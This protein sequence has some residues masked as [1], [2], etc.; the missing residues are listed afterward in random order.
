MKKIVIKKGSVMETL[1]IP[2]YGKKKANELYPDLFVDESCKDIFDK[3]VIHM[4]EPKK[5]KMKIG[6]IMAGT[7]QFDLAEVCRNYLQTHPEASVV[8]LGCGLD[9]TFNLLSAIDAQGYNIDFPDVI[10]ARNQLLKKS[11]NETNI[12]CDLMDFTWMDKIDFEQDKGAVFFASGL[13]YYFKKED[14]KKLFAEMAERFPGGKIAFDATN[15]KGLKK[16]LKTWLKPS[17]MGDVGI[18]FSL[19]DEQEILAWSDKIKSVVKKGY[20]SGYRPID[21]RFG[22]A[23]NTLFRYAEKTNMSQIIEIEFKK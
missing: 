12:A 23:V 20:M 18:Y 21:K 6:A 1:I 15:A 11:D 8:N 2:L 7:R 19:E 14:V 16:M 22:F 5:L 13:F 17:D 10:N 4:D 3:I 9:N